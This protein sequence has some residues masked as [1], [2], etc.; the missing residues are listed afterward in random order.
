[1]MTGAM[2]LSRH[3][4]NELRLYRLNLADV[5]AVV[6]EPASRDLDERGNARLTGLA[7]DGRPILVV[8]AADDPEFVITAFLRS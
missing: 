3:A 8:V 5:E 2:K 7:A 6:H 1:M 4:K